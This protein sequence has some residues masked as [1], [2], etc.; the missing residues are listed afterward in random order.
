MNDCVFFYPRGCGGRWLSYVIHC[1]H[2]RDFVVQKESVIHHAL[3][4]G[5]INFNHKFEVEYHDGKCEIKV[6]PKLK[7]NIL[8]STNCAFNIYI[9]DAYKVRYHLHKLHKASVLEQFHTL[10]DSARYLMTD[11]FYAANY[12]RDI[13]LDYA[14]IWQDPEQFIDDLFVCLDRCQLDYAANRD[15]VMVSMQHYRDTCRDPVMI[16]QDHNNLV[17]LA[18]C[19]AVCLINDIRLNHVFHD[20]DSADTISDILGP[21]LP[22]GVETATRLSFGSV[23]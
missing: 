21:Y 22:L 11:E 14:L 8:F 1:L 23:T 20:Q 16:M 10:T 3:V 17:W 7:T 19:H 4:K 15:F 12:F 18:W 13:D 5:P 2:R 6:F 9:N